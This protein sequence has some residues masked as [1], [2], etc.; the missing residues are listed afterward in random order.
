VT[1]TVAALPNI[2][3]IIKQKRTLF[4]LK[5]QTSFAN[6][7]SRRFAATQQLSRFRREA[8]IQRAALTEPDL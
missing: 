1:R 6:I 7:A 8:D 5:R 4:I 2:C 3:H